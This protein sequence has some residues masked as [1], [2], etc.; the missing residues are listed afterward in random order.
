MMYRMLGDTL[1][2]SFDDLCT[3]TYGTIG[4]ILT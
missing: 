4:P 3:F 1:F 2:L